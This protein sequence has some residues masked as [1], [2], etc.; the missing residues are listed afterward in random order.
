MIKWQEVVTSRCKTNN[1]RPQ[2]LFPFIKHVKVSPHTVETQCRGAGQKVKYCLIF[3]S[4]TT[5]NIAMFI[6]I[7]SL[8]KHPGSATSTCLKL[9][10]QSKSKFFCV[11]VSEQG[12]KLAAWCEVFPTLIVERVRRLLANLNSHPMQAVDIIVLPH[13]QLTL[14]DSESNRKWKHG[15]RSK[16]I[17]RPSA[18]EG[19]LLVWFL[20]VHNSSIG[21]LVTH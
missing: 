19:V 15:V 17:V 1:T 4:A 14:L 7:F 12:E 11:E 20:A 18:V 5:P 2:T 16:Y 8:L 9:L 13:R 6:K 21:D 10:Q 3:G